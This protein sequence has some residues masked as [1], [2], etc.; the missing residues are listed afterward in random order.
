MQNELK[1]IAQLARKGP[2]F[3]LT[4]INS[5][6]LLLQSNFARKIYLAGQGF[7]RNKTKWKQ[8]KMFASAGKQS[9]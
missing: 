4:E 6:V 3:N 1:S 9:R 8:W 2:Q 7:D 5:T